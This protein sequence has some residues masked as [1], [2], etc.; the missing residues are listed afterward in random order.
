MKDGLE[1][2]KGSEDPWKTQDHQ[3][4]RCAIS[5]KEDDTVGSAG[6]EEYTVHL[7]YP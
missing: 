1:F 5:M 4:M 7:I 6:K 2:Q 3:V